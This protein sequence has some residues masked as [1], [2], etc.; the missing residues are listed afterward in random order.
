[1][2]S[3]PGAKPRSAAAQAASRRNGANSTGPRTAAGKAISARNAVK[4]GLRARQP[5][6]PDDLPAWITALEANLTGAIGTIRQGRREELDRL[7]SVLV[8]IDRVDR[9]ITAELAALREAAGSANPAMAEAGAGALAPKPDISLLRK[10]IAYRR[11]FRAQR[12]GCLRRIIA[13]GN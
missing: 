5:M 3:R 1:M 2:A 13:P 10:L 8:L 12:D 11:R 9:S 7:L 4:H 6:R